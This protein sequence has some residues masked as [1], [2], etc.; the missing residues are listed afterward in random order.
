MKLMDMGYTLLRPLL[1][2]QDPEKAHRLTLRLLDLS[3]KLGLGQQSCPKALPTKVMGVH[4]PNPVGLAAGMD[5]NGEYIDALASLGFGY[6]EI[7]TV[8]PRAQ[9]GNPKTRLFRIVEANAIINRMG[10]NNAGVDVLVQNV[11]RS[12]YQGVLGINIGKNADTPME[13][14]IDDYLLC[15]HRVYPYASYIVV[16]ISSPNT[17]NLRDL[18]KGDTFDRLLSALKTEQKLLAL[19]YEK[20]VPLVIKIAPDL[21]EENIHTI[22]QTL[23]NHEIDG[24]ISSNTTLS[25]EGVENY[26]LSHE[27]GGLSGAPLKAK[28]D[29]IQQWLV[30]ALDGK[31]PVIG[32]G[33]IMQG[34]DAVTKIVLGAELVQIYSGMIY[35][36]PNLAN[37]CVQSLRRHILSQQ[38]P[39]K[40]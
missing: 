7:G 5:K 4:F 1:F 36:G 20:Y 15:L 13:N 21:N 3:Y 10:F 28:A 16:N 32:S 11:K 33:G 22:A 26:P 40:A 14:A 39:I 31:I 19:Q 30:S 9:G 17:S 12:R 29:Q 37:E 35:R 24:V 2:R 34:E 8:T 6:I 18:Q 38:V 27:T 25:R 23:I